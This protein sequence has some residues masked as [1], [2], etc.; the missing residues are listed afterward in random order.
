MTPRKTAAGK[1]ATYET[2]IHPLLLFLRVDSHPTEG[3]RGRRTRRSVDG[4]ERTEQEKMP[5]GTG[6]AATAVAPSLP[7]LQNLIKRD[8]LGYEDEFRRR[9]RH[10][11][12]VLELQRQ[13]PSCRRQG[14]GRQ[15][16]IHHARRSV[17][18]VAR[19]NAPVAARRAARGA[20]RCTATRAALRTGAGPHP[21]AQSRAHA[22]SR[23]SAAV[24]PAVP[25]P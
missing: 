20:A 10:F 15:R 5:R 14:P 13:Q 24:L 6:G 7:Q 4:E 3:D 23:P 18:S 19:R 2:G 25:L 22:S 11:Q 16:V 17:L 12:S 1:S 8:P 9:W 21:A